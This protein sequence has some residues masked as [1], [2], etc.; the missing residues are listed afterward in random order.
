MGSA[1]IPADMSGVEDFKKALEDDFFRRVAAMKEE[2]DNLISEK[3][4]LARRDTE[5]KVHSIRVRQR[6]EFELLL[7]REKR[8]ALLEIREEAMTRINSFLDDLS[9]KVGSEIENIRQDRAR[10]SQILASLVL[11]ALEAL[12]EDAVVMVNLGESA[13]VPVEQR[14]ASVEECDPGPEW[15]GCVILDHRTRSV[16]VNNSIK[17][18]WDLFQK[19]FLKEF[20]EIFS[21][22]LQGFNRFSRELRIP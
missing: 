10:Y 11:E 9:T 16:V 1:I 7:E 20:S 21:D 6:K 15:G 4:F 3:M 12:G 18:R 19:V 2:S 22:V 8:R 5:Q 17:T 14:I 13:M